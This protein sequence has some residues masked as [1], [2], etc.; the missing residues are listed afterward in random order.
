MCNER[1]LKTMN[2]NQ[3]YKTVCITC[4]LA[5]LTGCGASPHAQ[6]QQ[7]PPAAAEETTTETADGDIPAETADEGNSC[8]TIAEVKS[9]VLENAGFSEENVRFVR[10]RLDSETGSGKYDVE[11]VS[12]TVEYD[13]TVDAIT[14]EILSMNCETGNYDIDSIPSDIAPSNLSQNN[15]SQSADQQKGNTQTGN[16]PGSQQKAAD[17]Q[18]QNQQQTANSQSNQQQAAGSQGDQQQAVNSQ[19]TNQQQAADSQSNQQQ[20]GNSQNGANGQYIGREAAQQAALAHAGLDAGTVRFAH[21]HLEFD[22][23]RWQYDVE[24]HKGTEEYD[25]EIDALTGEILSYNYDTEYIKPEASAPAAQDSGYITQ[26]KA[27]QL[28]LAHAGISESDAQYLKVEFDY[29]DGHAEYEVEWN[30]GLMEY[31]CDV[32][33]STGGILSFKKELD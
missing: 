27:K 5:M 23:G 26:E 12:D 17:S 19:G 7:N 8:I 32:D 6:P 24:F 9:I 30:V 4:M 3:Y 21:T 25:Y 16:N 10:L 28:A 15:S 13:Y 1:G 11:F 29:D 33:A 31:S 20:T 18:S 2:Q 14:G 22:D